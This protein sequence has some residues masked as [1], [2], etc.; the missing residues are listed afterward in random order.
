M[1]KGDKLFVRIDSRISEREFGK[2]DFRD[3]IEYLEGIAKERY[4]LGGGFENRL[5]GMIIYEAINLEE[6]KK[7]ADNDPLIK[8]NL[9]TYELYEWSLVLLSSEKTSTR[10][11]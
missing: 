4:F 5:G 11:K 1:E 6:A 2:T 7:V 3:H 8:R 9:Y 10:N